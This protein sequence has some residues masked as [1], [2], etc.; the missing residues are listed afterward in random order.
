MNGVLV[1][2]DKPSNIKRFTEI[3]EDFKY[4]RFYSC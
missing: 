3:L 4:I 2:I 1:E